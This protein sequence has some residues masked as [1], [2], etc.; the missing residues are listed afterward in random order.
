MAPGALSAPRTSAPS[1]S[2]PVGR[3]QTEVV[4]QTLLQQEQLPGGETDTF[5]HLLSCAHGLLC[6][7]LGLQRDSLKITRQTFLAFA[8][9]GAAAWNRELR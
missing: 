6:S 1:S 3:A 9:A 4:E 8:E 7:G 5:A 2:R